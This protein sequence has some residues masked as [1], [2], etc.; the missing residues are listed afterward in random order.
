MMFMENVRDLSDSRLKRCRHT[1]SRVALS[2]VI[3]TR[4]FG[5]LTGS[6]NEELSKGLGERGGS[7]H[8][9][10]NGLA[11]RVTLRQTES[12]RIERG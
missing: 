12:L 7:L 1:N 6:K 5:K 9:D 8:H 2:I 3:D 11:V 4:G 10:V